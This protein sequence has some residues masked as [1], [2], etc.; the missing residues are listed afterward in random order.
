MQF[1]KST[2]LMEISRSDLDM[3][4]MP[5]GEG[6]Q[7]SVYYAMCNFLRMK[8]AVRVPLDKMPLEDAIGEVKNHL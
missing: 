8:F 4:P 1:L 6:G 3:A 2:N 5:I 7:Y